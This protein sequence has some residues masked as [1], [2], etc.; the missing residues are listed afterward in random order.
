MRKV[1]KGFEDAFVENQSGLISLCLEVAGSA[2]VEDIYAYASIEEKSQMFNA[3]FRVNGEIR[4]VNQLTTDRNLMMQFLK[5]GTTD[6]NKLRTVCASFDAPLPTEMKL[7]YN[8]KT[9][10]FDGEC[11]YESVCNKSSGIS[12]GEV[13]MAWLEEMKKKTKQQEVQ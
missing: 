13:F 11:K 6:L 3:F 1:Q 8:N 7:Y 2:K 12:S 4:T 10:K 5:M 9:R